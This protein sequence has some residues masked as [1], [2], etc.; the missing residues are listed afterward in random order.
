MVPLL[1]RTPLMP[2]GGVENTHILPPGPAPK[3]SKFAIPMGEDMEF[4]GRL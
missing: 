4:P 1:P 2:P 3:M